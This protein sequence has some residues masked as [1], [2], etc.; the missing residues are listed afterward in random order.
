M[1]FWIKSESV[2][3]RKIRL[4]VINIPIWQSILIYYKL[5]IPET[6]RSIFYFTQDKYKV[7]KLFCHTGKKVLIVSVRQEIGENLEL[8]GPTNLVLDEI[9][10]FTVRS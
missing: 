6:E 7:T 3:F 4:T 1:L 8:I 9:R 2:V 10:P 5:S